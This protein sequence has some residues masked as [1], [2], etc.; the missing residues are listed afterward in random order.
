M[1]TY[2]HIPKHKKNKSEINEIDYQQ[3]WVGELGRR[4]ESGS[5]RERI[6]GWGC[7]ISQST[8][9]GTILSCR[10]IWIMHIFKVR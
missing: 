1:H 7:D 5:N 3:E 8:H 4:M 9:C 6:R 2:I 10:S